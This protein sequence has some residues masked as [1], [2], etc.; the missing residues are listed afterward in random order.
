MLEGG[1]LKEDMS[2]EARSVE[3]QG[4]VR[5]AGRVIVIPARWPQLAGPPPAARATRTRA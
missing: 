4:H 3:S 2:D 5:R 1:Q